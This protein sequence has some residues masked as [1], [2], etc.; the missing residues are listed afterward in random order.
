M[1]LWIAS[2]NRVHD[3]MKQAKNSGNVVALERATQD[4]ESF[5]KDPEAGVQ[6]VVSG[7]YGAETSVKRESTNS[8]PD[9]F[10]KNMF[11]R[12][13]TE[14][15]EKFSPARELAGS[16][17]HIEQ[18]LTSDVL[19]LLKEA[20]EAGRITPN[21]ALTNIHSLRTGHRAFIETTLGIPFEA[22]LA[23]RTDAWRR[24]QSSSARG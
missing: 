10:L 16:P 15:V 20:M 9:N 11:H 4:L 5:L 24:A 12:Y 18:L 8:S 14:L 2:F 19:T 6:M 17:K 13:Y 22:A 3:T 1:E 21:E 7:K 23:R